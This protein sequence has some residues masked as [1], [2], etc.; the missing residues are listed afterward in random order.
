[1]LC[2]VVFADRG[3]DVADSVGL[4]GASLDIPA[5]T[6]RQLRHLKAFQM[7]LFD[8]AGLAFTANYMS[9]PLGCLQ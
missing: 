8:V 7:K 2:D 9:N 1:M 6:T 4:M 3:L 5:F